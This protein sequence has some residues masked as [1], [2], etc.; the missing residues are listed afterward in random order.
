MHGFAGWEAQSGDDQ[1][2]PSIGPIHRKRLEGTLFQR[3]FV[4]RMR[5][6]PQRIRVVPSE[7]RLLLHEQRLRAVRTFKQ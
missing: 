2:P 5:I 7:G 3:N 4:R 1:S 6:M